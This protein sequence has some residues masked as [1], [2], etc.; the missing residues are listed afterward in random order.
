MDWGEGMR[1]STAK[2]NPINIPVALLVNRKTS[3]AAEA[4]AGMMRQAGFSQVGWT[5]Y[6]GGVVALHHGWAV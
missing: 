1:N 2:S 3:G 5:N 6:T 4:L